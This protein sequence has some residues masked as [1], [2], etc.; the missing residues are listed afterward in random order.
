MAALRDFQALAREDTL[1]L[2][3]LREL[4]VLVTS[5]T[6]LADAWTAYLRSLLALYAEGLQPLSLQSLQEVKIRTGGQLIE[7]TAC[8]QAASSIKVEWTYAIANYQD[9]L[10]DWQRSIDRMNGA[11]NK[12]SNLI[13]RL[14]NGDRFNGR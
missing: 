2:E 5:Q 14:H 4:S 10:H 1:P 7:W 13:A 12:I 3:K 11:W 6:Q 9:Y 8:M